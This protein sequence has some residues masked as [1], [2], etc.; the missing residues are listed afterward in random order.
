MSKPILIGCEKSGVLRQAMR[1]QGYE[2]YSCD[3][4]PSE[5]DSPHHIQD[6][7]LRVS[8]SNLWGGAIMHPECTFLSFSGCKHLF[9]NPGEMPLIP[10]FQRWEDMR[11]AADFFKK[12][13]ALPFPV[14][15][16][17]PKMHAH[18]LAALWRW[19][20]CV[21]QPHEHG[22]PAFKETFFWRNRDDISP[23][24]PTNPLSVPK[25]GTP[26]YKQWEICFR[27]A[28]SPK[29]KADRS[30]TYPGIAR[31]LASQ[32]GGLLSA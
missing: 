5:D 15:C 16:E 32:Y 6:D 23:L 10:E 30:K 21:T 13:L 19:P 29:R 26:E 17:N 12:L 25:K 20:F 1:E 8:R 2:A 4:L 27:A 24:K 7:V 31:A 22:D 28:P 9:K 3:I 18:G 14:I 11:A